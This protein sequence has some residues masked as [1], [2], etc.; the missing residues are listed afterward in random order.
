M[1]DEDIRKDYEAWLR[2]TDVNRVYTQE[3]FW[4]EAFKAGWNTALGHVRA[5]NG[6]GSRHYL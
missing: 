4:T 2:A 6:E 1:S 3:E 5:T